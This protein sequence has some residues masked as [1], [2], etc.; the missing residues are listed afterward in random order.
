MKKLWLVGIT[1]LMLVLGSMAAFS[2][3]NNP[4]YE[5]IIEGCI[6]QVWPVQ[7]YNFVMACIPGGN[8]TCAVEWCS[9]L[10]LIR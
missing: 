4:V 8:Q 10:G 2:N 9:G 3:N 6:T 7:G 1:S 5:P